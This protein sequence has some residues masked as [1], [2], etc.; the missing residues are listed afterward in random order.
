MINNNFNLNNTGVSNA[1]DTIN[2]S[3]HRWYYYKEG[4]SPEL[5]KS[6]IKEAELLEE[7]IILDPFN[8]SGTVTLTASTE[9]YNSIGFEVNPFTCFIAQTK[10]INTSIKGFDK[11]VIRTIESCK[12]QK[13]SNLESFSTF[14]ESTKRDKWLFNQNVLRTFEAGHLNLKN[15]NHYNSKLLKL[16]LISAA[17]KNSNVKKDGKC[18]RYKKNWDRLGYNNESFLET[19]INETNL[20]KEDL[21]NQVKVKPKIYN[22]DCRKHIDKL[23]KKFKLCIT[24]PPYLNTFDYTD[25]YRPELFIGDFIRSN[26]EL[27]NLRLKTLRSHVQAN[28]K[29]PKEQSYGYSFDEV[30]NKIKSNP[31]M[32][33]HK[34]IPYMILAYFEDMKKIFVSLKEKAEKGASLWFVVSTSAYA[35]VH[36][37]VDLILADIAVQVGWNLKEIGVLREIHKRKTKNSPDID[38]LRESVIILKN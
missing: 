6:A 32:L 1:L 31:E 37:P 20:I 3:R 25:I 21:D 16:A 9:G 34:N 11:S 10:I 4:F 5:V 29:M 18:V 15:E 2:L 23:D 35:N 27:Y 8:G 17:M 38:K 26:E 12:E 30:Y 24:S 13:I 7:D 28:W 36:I 14:S 33:M 19:F 22:V